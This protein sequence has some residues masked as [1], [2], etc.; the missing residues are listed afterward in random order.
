MSLFIFALDRFTKALV[1][2]RIPYQDAVTVIPGFFRLTHVQNRGAAFSILSESQNNLKL[3]L[4]IL[5]SLAAVTIISIILWRTGKLLNSTG[6][7]LALILGGA[8]GNL[9]DRVIHG[10]VTDFLEFTIVGYHWPD[11]NFA[12]SAI[13]IGAAVLIAEILW[14]REHKQ[15][16]TA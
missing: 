9:W 3:S 14:A 7:A 1:Q 2:R 13:V 12:D 5:F 10:H 6:I 11:F 15:A 16:R 8:A 4:L